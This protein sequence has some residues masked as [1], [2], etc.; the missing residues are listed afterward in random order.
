VTEGERVEGQDEKKEKSWGLFHLYVLICSALI[1]ALW[2]VIIRGGEPPPPRMASVVERPTV[3]LF[4]VDTALKRY[5]HYGR[6]RY[7]EQLS[8]L[9]PRHVRLGNEELSYLE[10]LSYSKDPTGG[11]RLA[12]IDRNTGDASIILSPQGMVSMSPPDRES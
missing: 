2:G 9:L 12:L 11:Y 5:A 10:T 8:E 4:L 3:L 1:V 6:G 7:P